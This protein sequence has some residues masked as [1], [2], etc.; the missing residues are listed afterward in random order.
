[1]LGICRLILALAVALS[2][3]NVRI[4]GLNPGVM[5]V[6][7][8]YMISGYVMTGLVKRHYSQ[9]RMVPAFYADRALRIFPQYILISGLTLSWFFMSDIHTNFLQHTPQWSE[10]ASNLFV[11]PLNYYMFNGADQFTL[12]PPAWSLGAELQFY[13]LFPF[14]LIWS[15]RW[16]TFA[17]GCLFL[18]LASVGKIHPDYFGYRL[19]PGVLVYF[20]LGSFLFEIK[21]TLRDKLRAAF[22]IS[23]FLSIAWAT[24]FNLKFLDLPYN[25]E[26]MVGILVGASMI[27]LFANRQ[28][29]KFDQRCGDLSYGVFLNHFLI[30]WTLVKEWDSFSKIGMY[31]VGAIILS[32]VTQSLVERPI[33]ILRKKLR[34]QNG[35][36]G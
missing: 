31:L 10:I 4:S 3:I 8:F 26:V 35:A 18:A 1:M 17:I 14:L 28:A 12:V 33:L 36:H 19:L 25:K 24:L 34:K 16:G 7:C 22:V 9:L 6:V 21:D 5:A 32:Y 23:L 11:I 27:L 29:S 30:Q 2:H 13:L 15:L 20:L